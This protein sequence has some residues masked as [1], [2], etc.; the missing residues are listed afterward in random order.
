MSEGVKR[1][2][3]EGGDILSARNLAKGTLIEVLQKPLDA[4]DRPCDI[5]HTV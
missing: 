5:D 3:L 1:H 4:S 2:V